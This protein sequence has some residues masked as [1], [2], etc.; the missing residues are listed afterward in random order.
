MK[1]E[2]KKKDIGKLLKKKQTNQRKKMSRFNSR[3]LDH[4]S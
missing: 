2:K 4:V 3:P 1:K